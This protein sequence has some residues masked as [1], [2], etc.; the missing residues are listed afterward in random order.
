A[1]RFNRIAG[2]RAR[3]HYASVEA[4][5]FFE[6]AV[7]NARAVAESIPPVELAAAY[8]ALADVA[9]MSGR[10]ELA[11]EGLRGA[12]RLAVSDP[13]W[14]ARLCCKEGRL[15]ERQGRDGAA[16]RWFRRG[17]SAL[18]AHDREIDRSGVDPV[19][20]AAE[21]GRL[22]AE[23]ASFAI[24]RQK[25]RVGERRC[26][27]AL[28]FAR[29]GHDRSTEAHVYYLLEWAMSRLGD[30][31]AYTYLDFAEPIYRE[32][33]DYVGL[34]SV[35]MNR[36]VGLIEFGDWPQ[37]EERILAA[38]SAYERGG[39]V[40]M[41][42]HAAFNLSEVYVDQGRHDEAAQLLRGARRVFRSS[43]FAM[44]VAAATSAL[45]RVQARGGHTDDGLAMLA[46]AES[47]FQQLGHQPFLAETAVRV[48]EALVFGGRWHDALD[49]LDVLGDRAADGGPAIECTALRLRA[50]CAAGL[51][52][53][54]EAR[55]ALRSLRDHATTVGVPWEGWYADV[56]LARLPG[57]TRDEREVRAPEARRSLEA[58]GVRLEQVLPPPSVTA[59]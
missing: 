26:R 45:G 9:M 12:R 53:V 44:G 14:M 4:T 11:R 56:E 7:D 33:G 13:L 6:R 49:R 43:G 15:C 18:A 1:W 30:D 25:Y 29:A 16:P 42:A 28:E 37:A 31:Q 39:D 48:A 10:F 32:I 17:L 51:G 23:W 8:E 21:C 50:L 58:R 38:R 52:R 35:L 55:A 22:Q 40:V 27:L 54:E 5:G 41:T 47:R 57:A 24:Q 20:V 19:A 46:E 2:E 34:G 59:A 3:D 36:G